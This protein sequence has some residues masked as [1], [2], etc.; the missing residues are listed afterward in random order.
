MSE[1]RSIKELVFQDIL[2]GLVREALL[3]SEVRFSGAKAGERIAEIT[4]KD[5]YDN[6]S[7]EK[8]HYKNCSEKESGVVPVN[9]ELGLIEA[10]ERLATIV[11]RSNPAFEELAKKDGLIKEGERLVDYLKKEATARISKKG[12]LEDR[13]KAYIFIPIIVGLLIASAALFSYSNSVT[14]LFVVDTEKVVMD[15]IAITAFVV[16]LITLIITILKIRK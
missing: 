12:E 5:K 15:P 9:G 11:S 10:C 4:F 16:F 13:L 14:G 7:L 2:G 3:D 8:I 1:P 6:Q